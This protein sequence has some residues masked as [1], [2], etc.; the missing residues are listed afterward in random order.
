[1]FVRRGLLRVPS[2]V[3]T[4]AGVLL[5]VALAM[6]AAGAVVLPGWLGPR[7][8]DTTAGLERQADE[9]GRLWRRSVDIVASARGVST[10]EALIGSEL[11]PLVTT[12][13]EAEAKRVSVSPAWPRA[14]V[15]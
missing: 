14:L 3:Q 15:R 8:A 13:G 2:R 6:A 9:A 1:M 7:S 4:A 11:T 12:L 5:T 10:G